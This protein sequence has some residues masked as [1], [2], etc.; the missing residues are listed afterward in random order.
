MMGDPE[1]VF[2]GSFGGPDIEAPVELEGVA[3]DDFAA[4]FLGQAQR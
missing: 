4:E 3:I 2:G 1:P